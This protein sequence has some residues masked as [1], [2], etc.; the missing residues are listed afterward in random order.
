[1]SDPAVEVKVDTVEPWDHPSTA[2][3]H[4]ITNNSK[5]SDLFSINFNT[6]EKP[7]NTG[8]PA[9]LYNRHFSCSELY[10]KIHNNPDL[11]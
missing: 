11:V 10:T 6:L 2:E 9:T 7:L 1:M 8:H 5:S 3:T 4:N